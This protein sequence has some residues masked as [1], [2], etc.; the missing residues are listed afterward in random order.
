MNKY[1]LTIVL[2]IIACI[3]WGQAQSL[4]SKKPIFVCPPCGMSCDK[5]KF[6]KA[7]NCPHCGMGLVKPGNIKPRKKVAILL[8]DGVQII[9]YTGPYEV[10]GQARYEVYTVAK[11]NKM[12]T[13]T[14]GMKVQPDY[15]FANA[16]QPDILVIPGGVVAPSQKD[17][18][19][20]AWI[21]RIEKGTKHLMS[22]CNGAFILAQ[23]KL[24]D[25][26]TA[27]TFYGQIA[28]LRKN[29]PQTKVVS[30]QRFVDNGRIITSAGL[31]AGIEAALRVVAK[32]KGLGAAQ[33]IALHIEYMWQPDKKFARAE[34]A[35]FKYLKGTGKMISQLKFIDKV[36]FTNNQGDETHWNASWEF[37][38]KEVEKVWQ[39]IT[40][41]YDKQKNTTY[42]LSSGKYQATWRFKGENQKDW[43]GQVIL[44]PRQAH[45]YQLM[46]KI[47]QKGK[48]QDK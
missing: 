3:T 14:F 12:V 23:T 21:K 36:K 19:T 5:L 26:K 7:G 11:A 2:G 42:Q 28:S 25:H 45:H 16:P 34:F 6:D 38:T 15:S 40:K 41:Y 35:D 29:F 31:S 9:D 13:T 8:F 24:L 22:V 30:N 32:E 46:V 10:F 48:P 44:R 20:I 17:D 47:W 43:I 18:A 1:L 4:A 27:T 33:S 37:E 39:Q